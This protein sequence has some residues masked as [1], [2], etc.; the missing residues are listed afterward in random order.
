MDR[1]NAVTSIVKYCV[2]CVYTDDGSL[3]HRN[4]GAGLRVTD[5][6]DLYRLETHRRVDRRNYNRDTQHRLLTES[7]QSADHPYQV[8]Y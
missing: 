8:S 6:S 5:P 4:C 3:K 2:L 7:A 1:T